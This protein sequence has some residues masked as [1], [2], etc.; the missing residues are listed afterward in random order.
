[1]TGTPATPPAR[2]TPAG[3][4]IK[5]LKAAMIASVVLPFAML[6]VTAALDYGRI[7]RQSTERV[8][9]TASIAEEHALKVLETGEVI[10]GRVLDLIDGATGSD[11]A[12]REYAL[13]MKLR[14]IQRDIGQIQNIYAWGLSGDALINSRSYPTPRVN[15]RDREDF[16][17]HAARRVG[18]YITQ[19]LVGRATGERFFNISR[20]RETAD[21]R[22]AG[23]VTVSLR[24]EYFSDFYRELSTE[25]GGMAIS[26][27][28]SDGS[29]LARYPARANLVRL[30][31]DS[32]LARFIASGEEIGESRGASGVDG[33]ERV[34]GFRKIGDYP[35][36]ISAGLDYSEILD[37]WYRD[38][39]IS[40]LFAVSGALGLLLVT[41]LALQKTRRE[42]AAIAQWRAEAER[43][44]SAEEALRQA[45]RLEAIGQ[46]TGGVAHD[47]NNLLQVISTNLYILKL[48][49]RGGDFEPQL[50]AMAR[51]LSSGETLTKHLLAFSRRRPLQP[52]ALHLEEVFDEMQT[53]MRHTLR[54]NVTLR[55]V[56]QP[57]LWPV[58]ADAE[59]LQMA[60]LNIAVNA[61]DALPEGGAVTLKARNAT[62]TGAEPGVN[63]RG[64]YVAIA[65]TDNGQG[66]PPDV[67]DRVFEPFFTTKAVGKGTGLGLS[68]VY[69]FAIQSGGAT[70]IQSAPGR[71]TTVT[72]YLPRSHEAPTETQ[73]T[74]GEPQHEAATGKVLLV[75]D[76]P[77]IGNAVSAILREMGYDV[78]H[79]GDADEAL[80][81]I[82]GGA[83]VDLLIT[84]I[85]MPGSMSGLD[86]ARTVRTHHPWLP[87][88]L[89]SGYTAEADKAAA[90]GYR[91]LSKPFRPET[92]A[93]AIRRTWRP[94]ESRRRAANDR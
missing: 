51:A 53:L 24:P 71:G 42:Q 34:I 80:A 43:R 83:D 46:L 15:I 22:F 29:L 6:A 49:L 64:D 8:H 47:F 18:T 12:A 78:R 21:G 74:E 45:Q 67:L 58:K 10:I 7:M 9:K 14:Q 86:L 37:E 2:E 62:L 77:E 57:G 41:W 39:G 56:L 33:V 92:L 60:L 19:P 5:W 55:C 32:A 59:E 30:A 91:I 28:R 3:G 4:A 16:E 81:A 68:Q 63:L 72:I 13:H 90:E 27:W 23:V 40:A 69:G 89:M 85:V 20:R 54:G 65:V 52:R 66:I 82:R 38:L 11:I 88:L 75:E 17:A 93:D 79:V 1:M 35:L 76:N 61:R 48:K 44:A 87:V 84:D 73:R 36:Y 26:I 70:T 31:N 50:S 94:R 25:R